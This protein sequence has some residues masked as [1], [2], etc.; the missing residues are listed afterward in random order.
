MDLKERIKT[1][2]V[3]ELDL[4]DINPAEIINDAPLFGDEG[5]GLDS[6]DAVEIVVLV[7]KFFY[8]EI[9]DVEQGQIALQSINSLATFILENK[10]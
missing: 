2:L 1:M 10:Q 3:E 7:E 5:L 6:L 8:A 4:I 9:Q